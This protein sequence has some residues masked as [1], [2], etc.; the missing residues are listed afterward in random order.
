MVAHPGFLLF[1]ATRHG[2]DLELGP[3]PR[4]G[5]CNKQESRGTRIQLDKILP[6]ARG[7]QILL[8]Q[9]SAC[10]KKT[11]TTLPFPPIGLKKAPTELKW[12]ANNRWR[13]SWSVE[14]RGGSKE[15]FQ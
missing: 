2:F 7:A 3:I 13:D 15:E 6:G 9:E 12:P 11:Q 14:K 10:T 5:V 8:A 1:N 4:L